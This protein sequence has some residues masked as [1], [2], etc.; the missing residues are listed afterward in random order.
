M[1]LNVDTQDLQNWPGNVKRV[2][3]DQS[4]IVLTGQEGDEQFVLSFSTSAYSDN[5]DRTAIPDLYV[6]TMKTGWCKSSG[7]TGTGGKFDLTS[8]AHSLKINIDY[9]S[10]SGSGSHTG[11]GFYIIN[12]NYD[13]SV[14]ISGEVIA[15]D[16]QFKIRSLADNLHDDDEG[17]QLSYLNASVEYK[18][19]RF[20][21]SSGS[22]GEYFNGEKR[23]SVVVTA[24]DNDDAAAEL[25]FDLAI[26]SRDIDSISV[27]ESKIAVDYVMDSP[28]LIINLGTGV[29]TGDCLMIT[30]GE[31]T[32]YFTAITGTVDPSISLATLA[33]NGYTGITESYS[34]STSKVQ[35]LREQ[36][37]EVVPNFY[38]TT[39]DSICRHGIKSLVNQIDYSS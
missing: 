23:T 33:V 10:H 13:N 31:H 29:E 21:I 32:D 39:I 6:T 8:S 20:F 38:H 22:V 12:L 24:V 16:L 30:D 37:P 26:T 5:T 14:P 17:L 25:G 18:N 2:T 4:N 7:L 28:N 3:L 19:S 9:T 1:A 27:K 11:D 15:D 35:I 34:K 36:D